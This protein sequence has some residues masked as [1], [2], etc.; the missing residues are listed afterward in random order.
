ML[1]GI[2]RNEIV[3]DPKA[4][5]KIQKIARGWLQRYKARKEYSG[6]I[7]SNLLL[8]IVFIIA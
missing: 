5:I 4:V 2:K 6:I 1:F 7:I 3:I 8:K